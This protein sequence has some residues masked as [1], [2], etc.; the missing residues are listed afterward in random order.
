M[1]KVL[2]LGT[3]MVAAM[4]LCEQAFDE[5]LL[6]SQLR[7]RRPHE[8]SGNRQ[9]QKESGPNDLDHGGG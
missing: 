1:E 3:P 5:N 2:V 8:G 9:R 7:L 4:I 6:R